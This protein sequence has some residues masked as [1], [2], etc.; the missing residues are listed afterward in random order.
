MKKCICLLA[1][2]VFSTALCGCNAKMPD[3]TQEQTTLISEYATHLLVKHSEIADRN[4]LDEADLEKGIAREAEEKERKKKADAIA[5][6]YLN[7]EVTK[8]EGTDTDDEQ[9]M[10]AG[11]SEMVDS[12]T[13]AEFM[14]EDGFMIDYVSYELCESYPSVSGEDFYIAMDA[15]PGNQLCVVKISVSNI[16]GQ[17]C[18]LD[19]ISKKS[20]FIMSMA[21]GSNVLAQST[22]LLD[23]FASYKGSIAADATEQMV[24]VFEVDDTI[25]QLDSAQLVIK[26]DS[27]EKM[28]SIY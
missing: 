2:I 8:V 24:L 28:V 21:D 16:S 27:G 22:M 10:D 3:L 5:Q 15:T 25:T 11:Q 19:M 14:E 26:N 6:T 7:A 13:I 20:K 23:D 9:E 17:D 4:L 18:E 1:V 12:R